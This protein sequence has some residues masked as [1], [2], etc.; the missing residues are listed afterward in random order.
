MNPLVHVSDD[1][2]IRVGVSRI[3]RG[4]NVFILSVAMDQLVA[5]IPM[6]LYDICFGSW[7]LVLRSPK[8][9]KS[10]TDVWLNGL[11]SLLGALSIV[12]DFISLILV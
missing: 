3:A 11:F 5:H 9:Y 1:A 10:M 8:I 4:V 6:Y 7:S 2:V 12:S